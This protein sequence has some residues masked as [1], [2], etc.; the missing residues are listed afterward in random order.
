MIDTDRTYLFG[1]LLPGQELEINIENDSQQQYAIEWYTTTNRTDL[2]DTRQRG[3]S[4]LVEDDDIGR[5]I[6]AVVRDEDTRVDYTF[7]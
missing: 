7:F 4:Y 3:E 6:T 1:A 2:F 5:E